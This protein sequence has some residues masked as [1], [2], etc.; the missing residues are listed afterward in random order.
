MLIIFKRNEKEKGKK[1]KWKSWETRGA[2]VNEIVFE[3]GCGAGGGGATQYFYIYNAP[4]NIIL[5]I[6]F[7]IGIGL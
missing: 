2:G 7:R 6:I 1:S 4:Y 5:G 3:L